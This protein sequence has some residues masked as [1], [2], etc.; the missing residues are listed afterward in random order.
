MTGKYKLFAGVII[1]LV[2]VVFMAEW[3]TDMNQTRRISAPE[4]FAKMQANPDAIIL[5][6]RTSREFATGRI[7]GAILLPDYAIRDRAASILPDKNA[8]I[9]V[10]CQGG[11]RSREAVYDLISMGYTNVFDFGGIISWPYDKV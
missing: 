7:P 4:A 9:L 3:G 11:T 1:A 8:L 10:Y 5:D 2:A 6:V